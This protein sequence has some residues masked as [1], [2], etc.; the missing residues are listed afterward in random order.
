[1]WN[2]YLTFPQSTAEKTKGAVLTDPGAFASAWTEASTYD[3]NNI[4]AS[5]A[6]FWM[7]LI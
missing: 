6:D 1:M 4:S 5:C 3:N 7:S 2:I